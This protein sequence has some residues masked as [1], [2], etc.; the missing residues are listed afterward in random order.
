MTSG[1]KLGLGSLLAIIGSLG[2]ILGPGVGAA[3][4]PG[5]WSFIAGFVAGLAGG[6]GAALVIFGLLERRR[7]R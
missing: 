1:N 7:G 5:P 4:L 6:L 3:S 2:I